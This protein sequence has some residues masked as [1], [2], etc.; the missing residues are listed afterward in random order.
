MNQSNK[1]ILIY[2]IDSLNKKYNLNLQIVFQNN[3]EYIPN[4]I[5]GN[6]YFPNRCEVL[7]HLLNLPIVYKNVN[8]TILISYYLSLKLT[9]YNYYI[10]AEEKIDSLHKQVVH[11]LSKTLEK[12]DNLINNDMLNFYQ[13]IFIIGH[14]IHHEIFKKNI[15]YYKECKNNVLIALNDLVETADNRILY[16]TYFQMLNVNLK[17]IINDEN[18]IEEFVC[19]RYSWIILLNIFIYG[20]FNSQEIIDMSI[21]LIIT[22]DHLD[23]I[24]ILD[25]SMTQENINKENIKYRSLMYTLRSASLEHNIRLYIMSNMNDYIKIF[26]KKLSRC[27]KYKFTLEAKILMYNKMAATLSNGA[28]IIDKLEKDRLI[29]KIEENEKQIL[30]IK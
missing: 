27:S 19:D 8:N 4:I 6:I 1:E 2:M 23:V 21:G 18:L 22:L 14:E 20:G 24:K 7:F 30:L 26:E 29:T 3:L 17:D 15:E 16:S 9:E 10:L 25:D 5:G 11:N 12:R 28:E 13:I